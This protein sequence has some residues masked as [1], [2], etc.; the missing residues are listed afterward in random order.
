MSIA[1]KAFIKAQGEMGKAIKNAANPHLKSKYADLGSVMD[2][3]MP[4][5]HDNGFGLM[6]PAGADERGPY[7]DTVLLHDSGEKF[8]S[9]VHLIMGKADMQALGSAHTYARRYGL[10][11]M[12]GLAPEDDDGEATKA[13]PRQAAA[14]QPETPAINVRATADRIIKTLR[15]QGSIED[16]TAAWVA[17]KDARKAVFTADADLHETEIKGAF[18]ARKKELEAVPF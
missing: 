14:R 1:A 9:R 4:A 18:T 3:A 6:Q 7:V 5:L 8:T 12:A 11:G 13:P 15:Q 17:E 10:L 2:A 16:L